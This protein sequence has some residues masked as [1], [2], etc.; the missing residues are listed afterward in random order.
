MNIHGIDTFQAL[1][2]ALN[3][4]PIELRHNKKLP[5]G[6][7]YQFELGDDMGFPERKLP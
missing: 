2:L 5:I 1:Q 7:M 4:L 3:T 6:Q